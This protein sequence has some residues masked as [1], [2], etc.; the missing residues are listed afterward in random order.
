MLDR[1]VFTLVIAGAAAT[2][3]ASE[4][5]HFQPPTPNTKPSPALGVD[6]S[7]C[8]ATTEIPAMS[9]VWRE[10]QTA[11]QTAKPPD[12]KRLSDL[13]L[14][15]IKLTD[16][17]QGIIEDVL[18][19]VQNQSVP[20]WR[21]ERIKK[22]PQVQQE[23]SDVLRKVDAEAREAGLLARDKNL[24]KMWQLPQNPKLYDLCELATVPFPLPPDKRDLMWTLLERLQDEVN[25]LHGVEEQLG[26]LI[27]SASHGA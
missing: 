17:K 7:R 10:F 6:I 5:S 3:V 26:V 11:L 27:N 23:I 25:E 18:V 8:R 14:D 19:I 16:N 2:V 21:E 15:I 1:L 13:R 9:V 4:T 24:G 22:I 12:A 20:G